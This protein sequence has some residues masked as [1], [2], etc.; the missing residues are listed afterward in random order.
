MKTF[1]VTIDQ[2]LSWKSN[3][4]NICQK[5]CGG[6]SAIRRVKP[7]VNKETLISV[8]VCPYFDYCCDAWDVFGETQ[9]QRL[10]K[11]QNR[12]ARII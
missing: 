1:G 3:T 7:Y 12:A 8:Y 6:I 5:I 11:P 2:H 9:S 4:E 10:Q